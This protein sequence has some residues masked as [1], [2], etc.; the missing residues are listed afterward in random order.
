MYSVCVCEDGW[1]G[2]GRRSDAKKYFYAWY[3]TISCVL[4][5]PVKPCTCYKLCITWVASQQ[6]YPSWLLGGRVAGGGGVEWPALL[7]S[8]QALRPGSNCLYFHSQGWASE[9]NAFKHK[10]LLRNSTRD[11][12]G[13]KSVAHKAWGFSATTWRVSIKVKSPL[14]VVAQGRKIA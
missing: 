8:E 3:V 2:A 4:R 11:Q 14:R 6:L 7:V 12:M 10:S 1:G 5:H 9:K 13:L